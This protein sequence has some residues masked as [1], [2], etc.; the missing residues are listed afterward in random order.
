MHEHVAPVS[1]SADTG[2]VLNNLM[3]KVASFPF[4]T[5]TF[6]TTWSVATKL[7]SHSVPNK[8]SSSSQSDS[9]SFSTHKSHGQLKIKSNQ[10]LLTVSVWQPFSSPVFFFANVATFFFTCIFLF[11]NVAL[12][13][14]IYL[15]LLPT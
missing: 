1:K 4:I 11:L 8:L 2:S 12:R 14:A 6:D 10:I 9:E 3:M 15:G 13:V 7:S 5:C